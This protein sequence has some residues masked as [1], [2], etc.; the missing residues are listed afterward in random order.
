[1]CFYLKIVS[2]TAFFGLFLLK[3]VCFVDR[4][5]RF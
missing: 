2:F 4:R 3:F 1:M 5:G